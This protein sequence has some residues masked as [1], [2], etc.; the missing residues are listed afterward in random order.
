[1]RT[2]WPSPGELA[3]R[4]AGQSTGD[5][6]IGYDLWDGFF[7]LVLV[8]EQRIVTKCYYNWFPVLIVGVFYTIFRAW[9][10]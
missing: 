7:T 1:M 2:S 10:V 4:R 6:S 5:L 3:A 9:P 8:V